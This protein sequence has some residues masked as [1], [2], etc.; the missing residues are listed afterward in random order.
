MRRAVFAIIIAIAVAVAFAPA[1]F[2][3]KKAADTI[4]L[5]PKT[6]TLGP[7]TF[8]HAVH[9]KAYKCEECH[10]TATGGALKT[11]S[12]KPNAFHVAMY[13]SGLCAD[14]HMK[15]KA[16]AANAAAAKVPAKCADCHK[17]PA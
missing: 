17:K 14:C 12:A 9:A 2:A 6:G 10:A 13:K 15:I 5:T 8:T 7:I 11:A 3:Q 1:V 16:D 4:T